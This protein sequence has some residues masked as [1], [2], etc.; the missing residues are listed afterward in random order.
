[1]KPQ[2]SGVAKGRR[3][4]LPQVCSLWPG[5]GDECTGAS[6]ERP[7]KS[8]RSGFDRSPREC[9][10]EFKTNGKPEYKMHAFKVSKIQKRE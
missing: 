6:L 9:S 1:M 7:N 3:L 2:K 5:K 8:S 4:V 10:N